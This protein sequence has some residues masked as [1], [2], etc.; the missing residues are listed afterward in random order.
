VP[1]IDKLSILQILL[2]TKEHMVHDFHHGI[3]ALLEIT[4]SNPTSNPMCAL[5]TMSNSIPV[6]HDFIYVS[7]HA[8]LGDG[9]ALNA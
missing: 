6:V 1:Y 7:A 8:V 5:P 3:E 9:V 2:K 4:R